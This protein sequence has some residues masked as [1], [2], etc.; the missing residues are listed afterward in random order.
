MS[1]S[2]REFLRRASVTLA[3]LSVYTLIGCEH[4]TELVG[5]APSNSAANEPRQPEKPDSP[6]VQKKGTII[7]AARIQDDKGAILYFLSLV[8][9]DAPKPEA[10]KTRIDF[11]SH[12][13]SINPAK[14][15]RAVLFEKHGP[16]C[17]E[18]DLKAG[19][20]LNT[21]TTDKSRSFY[22]HGVFSLDGTKLYCAETEKDTYKGVVVIRDGTTFKE[23]GKFPTFGV[24]PHDMHMIDG[25]STLVITNGGAAIGTAGEDI[26]PCV[27]FVDIKA[28]KLLERITFPNE[29]INAGHLA[30]TSKKDLVVVSAPR[31]GLSNQNSAPGGI[32]LRPVGQPILTMNSPADTT[33]K[34]LGET[35]SVAIHEPTGVV[36]ATNPTGN[37]LTFWN[38]KEQRFIKSLEM[39]RPLGVALTLDG[40][41][42]A[43][44]YV[45]E[46]NPALQRI[47]AE[48]L[49][50]IP[51]S[52]IDGAFMSG[53]H[54]IAYDL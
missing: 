14:P 33:A 53:S 30:M 46:G 9:L 4:K 24:A 45:P 49:E 41:D 1:L 12:G 28:E 10:K 52:R 44:S 2:R 18:F 21:I 22:G 20:V 37:I 6:M 50:L 11:L 16:G 27:T 42:F 17:C 19:K 23:L 8:N 31:D 29:K 38:L 15:E 3:G 40:K 54:V 36:A 26:A 32:S 39:T 25:G 34:M 7:G 13:V 35:L 51:G 43:V 47:N 5:N 48:T